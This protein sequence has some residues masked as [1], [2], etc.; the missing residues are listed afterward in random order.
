MRRC[1]GL[2]GRHVPPGARRSEEGVV[3]FKIS[4]T[5]VPR[6]PPLEPEPNGSVLIFWNRNFEGTEE[7]NGSDAQAVSLVPHGSQYGGRRSDGAEGGHLRIS[8]THSTPQSGGPRPALPPIKQRPSPKAP[9][10]R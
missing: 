7:P 2:P 10:R 9:A 5:V 3:G 1:E 8:H 4:D 6:F